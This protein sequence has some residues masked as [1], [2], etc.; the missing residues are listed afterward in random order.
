MLA[1]LEHWKPLVQRDSVTEALPPRTGGPAGMFDSPAASSTKAMRKRRAIAAADLEADAADLDIDDTCP[2]ED[3]LE[4]SSPME[5][6][7]DNADTSD[8]VQ[9]SMG[10]DDSIQGPNGSG[11]EAEL[12][13]DDATLLLETLPALQAQALSGVFFRHAM[14]K[15]F[16]LTPKPMSRNRQV[17]TK[18]Q[19]V[20]EILVDI[21][22]T[23]RELSGIAA[24]AE[25]DSEEDLT[26]LPGPTAWK[27]FLNCSWQGPCLHDHE[28]RHSHSCGM[29]CG[30]KFRRF[31]EAAV[32]T[33]K[34]SK[35]ARRLE[36]GH[37]RARLVHAHPARPLHEADQRWSSGSSIVTERVVGV[38]RRRREPCDSRMLRRPRRSPLR[39]SGLHCKRG[40][41]Q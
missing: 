23:R 35:A 1:G 17:P 7:E 10:V 21:L 13:L 39:P 40:G 29:S 11:A 8:S 38:F 3:M 2:W 20:R 31:G 14:R 28:P 34:G 33:I 6:T 9:D 16:K 36:L 4:E 30:K 12:S 26:I 22:L 41:D 24:A 37:A 27:R 5:A 15:I 32:S 18:Q 19:H 25:S